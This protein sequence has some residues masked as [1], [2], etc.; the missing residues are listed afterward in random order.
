MVGDYKKRPE[1]GACRDE[2]EDRFNNS[3]KQFLY[4]THD[5]CVL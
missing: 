4:C 5:A 3:R 1:Q 2:V